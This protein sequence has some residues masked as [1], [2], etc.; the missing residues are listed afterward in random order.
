MILWPFWWATLSRWYR[1]LLGGTD[2]FW[3]VPTLSGWRH[4]SGVT[5]L[6]TRHI[7]PYNVTANSYGLSLVPWSI[8]TPTPPLSLSPIWETISCW[9]VLHPLLI[10]HGLACIGLGPP[11]D[12]ALHRVQSPCAPSVDRADSSSGAALYSM[13]PLARRLAEACYDAPSEIVASPTRIMMQNCSGEKQ[14][15]ERR[16]WVTLI[17]LI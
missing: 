5:W 2:T 13:P 3:V 6:R 16:G 1:T 9:C 7:M 8:L 4:F 17:Y 11:L 10:L 12:T 14:E 15:M